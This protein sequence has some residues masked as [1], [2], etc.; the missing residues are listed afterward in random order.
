MCPWMSLSKR[1]EE[2]RAGCVVGERLINHLLYVDDLVIMSPYSAGLQQLLKVCSDYG[3]W[4][5]VK[6]NSK[7][8][9]AMIAKT[10]EGQKRTFPFFFL[11]ENYWL[12]LTRSNIS[13]KLLSLKPAIP[14]YTLPTC[15]AATIWL[16]LKS[17]RWHMMMR[18]G[19][20]RSSRGWRVP[21]SCLCTYKFMV[22]LQNSN[23][24]IITVLI[25]PERSSTRYS[26]SFGRHL[27]RLFVCH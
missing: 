1:L 10:K 9:G 18:S 14:H 19:S 26:P 8:S 5:D 23:N 12:L 22:R 4:L 15:G 21:V 16:S 17:Y 2:C 24:E 7:K 25:V 3:K 6:F 11:E 13:W 20:C 27:E